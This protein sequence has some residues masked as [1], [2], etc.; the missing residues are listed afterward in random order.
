MPSAK[1]PHGDRPTGKFENVFQLC[2]IKK[3]HRKNTLNL[4]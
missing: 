3:V 4:N 2:K 1:T